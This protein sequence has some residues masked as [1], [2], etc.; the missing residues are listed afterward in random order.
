[1]D[2]H[3]EECRRADFPRNFPFSP[4]L[5]G[6]LDF[7]RHAG[8]NCTEVVSLREISLRKWRDM[9]VSNLGEMHGIRHAAARAVAA[10]CD[11]LMPRGNW[12]GCEEQT[13]KE[14]AASNS[15]MLLDKLFFSNLN[16]EDSSVT[17]NVILGTMTT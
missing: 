6:R 10:R 7:A 9:R 16:H 11:S 1:M 15:A 14:V 3:L 4:D 2:A 5:R 17:E 13:G 12:Q 8:K